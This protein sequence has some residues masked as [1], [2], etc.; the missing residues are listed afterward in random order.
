MIRAR[1]DAR[2]P[3]ICAKHRT[4]P[5][6]GA[7]SRIA[8]SECRRDLTEVVIL[9]VRARRTEPALAYLVQRLIVTLFAV[10]M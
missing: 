10:P 1:A 3:A 4:S 9:G 2:K 8:N 6:E 5:Q 7:M